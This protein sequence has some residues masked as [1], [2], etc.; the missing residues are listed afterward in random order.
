MTTNKKSDVYDLDA[1]LAQKEEATGVKEGRVSFTFKDQSFTFKDPTFLT[2][3]EVGE[4]DSLPEYGPD[5]AAWYMGD[6]EYDR[7]LTVGGSANLWS[8][9]LNEHLKKSRAEDAAGNPTRSN[10]SQRRT[11]ARKR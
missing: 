9:V 3:E 1:L 5:V 11:A 10:R 4:L 2:D 6:D 8:V 7:F